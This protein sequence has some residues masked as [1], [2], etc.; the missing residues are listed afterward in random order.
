MNAPTGFVHINNALVIRNIN[1]KLRQ[2]RHP[3]DAIIV[4]HRW[5]AFQVQSS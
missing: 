4:A 3:M 2:G 5:P 1:E